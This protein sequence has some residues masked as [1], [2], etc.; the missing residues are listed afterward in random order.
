MR[1]PRGSEIASLLGGL[2]VRQIDEPQVQE[3]DNG[4]VFISGRACNVYASSGVN[5]ASDSNES[6]G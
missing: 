4:V 5:H 1:P 2:L 3:H 6:S